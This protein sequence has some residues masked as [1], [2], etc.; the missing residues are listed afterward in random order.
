M[1][2]ATTQVGMA[3]TTD[4]QP[5]APAVASADPAPA[6]ATPAWW[7]VATAQARPTAPEP[8]NL[9]R[10]MLRL[11]AGVLAVV[12]LVGLLGSLAARQLA[13]REAVNDAAH[14]AGILAETVITPALTPGLLTGDAAA[15]A[16]LDSVVRAHV[17]SADV[18]RVKVWSPTGVVLYADEP[19]LIGAQFALSS[20]QQG[21]LTEPATRAEISALEGS[22]NTFEKADQLVEVYRP[23]WLADG[24]PL[25]FEMYAS[26]VPVGERTSQLW[27]GFAGV[28]VSS[29]IL[30]VVLVS[31][32]L[33]RLLLSLRA[34]Q[35]AR[36]AVLRRALDVSDSE[37]QRIAATLHDGPVQELAATSFTLAGA[38]AE[39]A[40]RGDQRRARDLEEASASVRSSIRALRSLL[41]DIYP[42][43]LS[44][45]GIVAALGDLVQGVR[46]PGMR[47]VLDT[48]PEETL[49]LSDEQM[50]AVFRIAQE[51]LRNAAEHAGPAT[52]TVTLRRGG[53]GVS[54]DIV[55]DGV[56]FDAEPVLSAPAADHFGLR[57]LRDTARAAGATLLLWSAPGE[58]TAWHLEL[59]P[60]LD[61]EEP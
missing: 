39:A 8:L 42:P 61:T 10:L 28:T 5:A 26:Y 38:A 2:R 13:E 12:A 41:V 40:N 15:I 33:R 3:P 23:V 56:G 37:R 16:A 1:T 7:E 19:Q 17:L 53:P 60:T 25:L 11:G 6:E 21:A 14:T 48:D 49:A 22:E 59:T 54:L 50:R 44:T 20:D 18:V 36:D 58:G 24:S 30:F 45:S 52:V 43:S 46:A 34:E 29:L 32:L 27:R 4:R 9:R 57:L 35:D 47:V 31:P 51:C 55:D